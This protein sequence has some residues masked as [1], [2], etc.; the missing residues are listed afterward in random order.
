M[1]WRVT[2]WS[3]KEYPTVFIFNFSQRRPS[4]AARLAGVLGMTRSSYYPNYNSVDGVDGLQQRIRHAS[5]IPAAAAACSPS[6][7]GALTM[8]TMGA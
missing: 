5:S 6:A 7:R 3:Y 1:F 2:G 8:Y 4:G